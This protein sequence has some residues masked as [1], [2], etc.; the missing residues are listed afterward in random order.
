MDE[1]ITVINE[2]TRNE[3][4]K[5]FFVNNKKF[6]ISSLIIL[7]LI[8][9]SFYSYKIYK[10]ASREKISEKYN[11]EII[12]Y[13]NGENLNILSAMKEIIEDKDTTYSPLALFFLIEND[14]ID[15]KVETNRLFD[16]LIDKTRLEKEIKYLI[17]YK[18]ALFNADFVNENQLLKIVNPIINSESIWKS[19]VLYL[20]AE[21][22]YSKNEKQ[23]SKEFFTKILDVKNANQ[24][25]IKK[26]Q[27]RLKRDLSD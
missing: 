14:L 13:K 1:D 19:H 18:K 12:D 26:T 7:I 6:L 17:I 10:N 25:I 24:D 9:V 5:N 16:I 8:I 21:Y 3:K 23:K 20:V 27:K 22:F 11:S 15:N 4:I 2:Q